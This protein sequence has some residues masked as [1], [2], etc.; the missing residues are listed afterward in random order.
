M[1]V[2]GDDDIGR[3]ADGGG[4]AADVW[5]DDHG[6]EHGH[7]IQLH[8]LAQPDADGRHEQWD[9]DVVQECGQQRREQTQRVDERPNAAAGHLVRQHRHVVEDSRLG[10][11][12]HDHHHREQQQQ[13]LHVDPRH[14]LGHRWP[15]K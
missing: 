4:G 1:L 6:H 14:Q 10:Q 3:V 7:G 13:R 15:L 8:H 12:G 2:G 9:G 5:V 11:D